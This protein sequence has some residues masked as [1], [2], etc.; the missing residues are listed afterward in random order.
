MSPRAN[1]FPAFI[2]YQVCYVQF[3]FEHPGRKTSGI[4]WDAS[5]FK[6]EGCGVGEKIKE[7]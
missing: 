2:C 4:S 7:Y 3:D 1:A 5:L 6:L